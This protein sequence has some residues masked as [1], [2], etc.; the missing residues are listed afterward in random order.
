MKV[1][2]R[3]TEVCSSTNKKKGKARSK[4]NAKV[5]NRSKKSRVDDV[6]I[7]SRTKCKL[8]IKEVKNKIVNEKFFSRNKLKVKI[9]YK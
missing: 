6:Q 4:L 9:N 2:Q 5:K 7:S 8:K 1:D 3:R